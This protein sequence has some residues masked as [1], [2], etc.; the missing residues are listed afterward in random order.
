MWARRKPAKLLKSP[1]AWCVKGIQEK[2]LTYCTCIGFSYCMSVCF[3][4]RR[5]ASTGVANVSA[6]FSLPAV[7][8][9]FP[10]EMS[11]AKKKV[12]VGVGGDLPITAR[13]HCLSCG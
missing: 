7:N 3:L 6:S 11:I 8:E 5:S 9:A 10:W 2:I 13:N 12:G 4:A 1:L